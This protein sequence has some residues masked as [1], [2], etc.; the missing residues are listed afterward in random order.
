VQLAEA[1]WYYD[2]SPEQQDGVTCPYCSLSLDG[3]DAGD[4][5]LEEHRRRAPDCLFFALKELYHPAAIPYVEKA[6]GKRASTRSSTATLKKS[7]TKAATK[8]PAKA[9]RGKK[10]ASHM[11][12][13]E[14]SIIEPGTTVIHHEPTVLRQEPNVIHYEPSIVESEPNFVVHAHDDGE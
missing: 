3:W 7:T 10:A 12:E 1:G 9:T 13:P 4:D 2:P 5:P 8:K 11:P 14:S 6:K